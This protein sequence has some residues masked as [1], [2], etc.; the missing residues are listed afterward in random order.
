MLVFV[1]LMGFF[2]TPIVAMADDLLPPYWRGAKG[3]TSQVWEFMDVVN[4]PIPPD[5]PALGGLDPL[6][7]TEIWVYPGPGMGWLP[8]DLGRLGVWPLSGRMD[9]IVD[10]LDPPNDEK[11]IYVQITWREQDIGSGEGIVF[12]YFEP[13]PS[14]QYPPRLVEEIQ[15]DLGWIHSTFEWRIDWNPPDETFGFSGNINVDEIVIDT[16][17]IPEP[18]TIVCL[19]SLGFF[20]GLIYRRRR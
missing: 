17:C 4:N 1:V 18:S 10:N 19:I 15:L 16:W 12:D 14:A 13:A 7:S 3:T 9:V 8:D 2:V 6:P 5:G 11:W 20:V